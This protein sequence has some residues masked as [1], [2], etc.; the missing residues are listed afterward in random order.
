MTYII[1]ISL[2]VIGTLIAFIGGFG[3]DNIKFVTVGFVIALI[4]IWF[5]PRR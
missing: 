5:R 2:A 4:G 3:Y 1:S